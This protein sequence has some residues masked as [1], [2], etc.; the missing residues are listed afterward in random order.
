MDTKLCVVVIMTFFSGLFGCKN[1][2]I[3]GPDFSQVIG[4]VIHVDTG[5]RVEYSMPGNMSSLFNYDERYAQESERT[6][7]VSVSDTSKYVKDNWQDAYYLDGASWD[8]KG[9]KTQG[10]RGDLGGFS[11]RVSLSQSQGE[12]G[13]QDY[14]VSAYDDFLN[15][16]N[17]V[18]TELRQGEGLEPNL[19]D[20]ELGALI[21]H[22]PNIQTVKING[23]E[24]LHW[25]I[26]NEY[27]GRYYTYFVRRV[28]QRNF[29]SFR[30]YYTITARSE[31]EVL[32]VKSRAKSDVDHMM[33]N[34][35]IIDKVDA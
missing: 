3:V 4:K 34:V 13:L 35:F 26:A 10:I 9:D 31:S 30:F 21:V 11:F 16:V 23:V 33:Q 20:E 8:Y 14:I 24:Y 17:G 25:S 15:G 6:L 2:P 19:S 32:D 22:A 1:M 12:G 7:S 28:D 27:P 18:N 5:V 29:I